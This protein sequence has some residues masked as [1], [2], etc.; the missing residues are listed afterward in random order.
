MRSEEAKRW[1]SRKIS[2]FRDV[3]VLLSISES[4]R[5]EAIAYLDFPSGRIV[6]ISTAASDEFLD[7]DLAKRK[8]GEGSADFLK[9]HGIDRPYLMHSSAFDKRKNFEGLLEAYA[10]LPQ[11][12]REAYQLVLV[13]KISDK[14]RSAMHRLMSNL[15][16]PE[17]DVILPG[18]VSD[19]E[20]IS[21]Y[22]NCKL[23]VFPSFHEG[24]GLPILEAMHCGAPVVGSNVSSIPEVIS[25]QSALFDPTSPDQMA[26]FLA[27]ILSDPARLTDLGRHSRVQAGKFNWDKTAR[28]AL[29]TLEG[30]MKEKGCSMNAKPLTLED[31]AVAISHIKRP[32]QWDQRELAAVAKALAKNEETANRLRR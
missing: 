29:Q 21:F 5:Q 25:N 17:N 9:K 3:D 1:Y 27:D 23:F 18:H 31:V 11:P 22:V 4:S 14:D 2:A 28:A 19:D 12:I 6:N 16:I 15:G 7:L 30:A 20:L 13:C 8:N 32:A 10:L 24:F 26:V